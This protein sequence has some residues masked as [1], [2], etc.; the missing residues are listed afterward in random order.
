LYFGRFG[1]GTF[2]G[3][4]LMSLD[5]LQLGRYVFGR[6]V[7]APLET[8]LSLLGGFCLLKQCI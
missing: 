7:G 5:V 1:A 2:W 3:W 4:D 6:F 8:H